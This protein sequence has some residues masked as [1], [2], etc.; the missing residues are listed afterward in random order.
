MAA[1]TVA[2]EYNEHPGHSGQENLPLTVDDI[3]GEREARQL[4]QEWRA[5]W[6]RCPSATIFQSPEWLLSWCPLAQGDLHLLTFRAREGNDLVGIAPFFCWRDGGERVLSLMGAGLSDYQDL[7]CEERAQAACLLALEGWLADTSRDRDRVEWSEVPAHSPLLR[8]E[9]GGDPPAPQD[10]CPGLVLGGARRLEEVV[11]ESQVWHVNHARRRATRELGLTYEEAS[12]DNLEALL[13]SLER[14]HHRRWRL[15]DE[16]GVLIDARVQS[17]WRTAARE[18]LAAGNLMLHAVCL[19]GERAA[20]MI[21]FHEPRATRC[22]LT[23]FEPRFAKQSPGLLAVAHA[24]DLALERNVEVCDFLRGAEPYKYAWGARDL[25]RIC[26][27]V[28][29][30]PGATSLS[31]T[32]A[33]T[34]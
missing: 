23:G 27:R 20:V 34:K 11:P 18:L 3:Q 2:T 24:V 33:E 1:A 13:D 30:G 9:L 15:R 26:R 31:S 6:S 21:G 4:R 19:G 29:R 32:A 5:L 22:Y 14:L 12:D 28:V 8:L 25:G 7:L 16:D 17:F 10:V